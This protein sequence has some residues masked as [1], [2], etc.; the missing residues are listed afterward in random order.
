ML[1]FHSLPIMWRHGTICSA[2]L[3]D[4][5]IVA[6]TSVDEVLIGQALTRKVLRIFV[7][8]HYHLRSTNSVSTS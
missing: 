4:V 3:E 7:T 1:M 5:R 2:K 8:L 6:A